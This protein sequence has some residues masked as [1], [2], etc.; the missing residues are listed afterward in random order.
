MTKYINVCSEECKSTLQAANRAAISPNP[1]NRFMLF[2][3]F[4]HKD[5]SL[6]LRVPEHFQGEML[7]C[8]QEE[9]YIT[10]EAFL[11]L[12]KNDSQ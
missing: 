3:E 1:A 5:G 4:H 7:S 9:A 6:T 10:E 2:K 12:I 11:E 8:V